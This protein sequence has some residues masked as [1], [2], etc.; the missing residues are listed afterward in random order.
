MMQGSTESA[1]FEQGDLKV[2]RGAH[3]VFVKGAEIHLTPIEF[4]LLTALVRNAG[5]VQT[6]RQLLAEVW[7]PDQT[8]D[9][10]YLRVFMAGLRRKIEDDPAQPAIYLPSK[11]SAIAFRRNR[12]FERQLRLSVATRSGCG[13]CFSPLGQLVGDLEC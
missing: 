2:D 13:E 10:H 4:K 6:H 5:K 8:Q 9:T 12:L 3:R 7:G 1:V 11:A